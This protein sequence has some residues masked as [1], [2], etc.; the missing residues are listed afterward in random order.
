MV[1]PQKIERALEIRRDIYTPPHSEL[2]S[3]LARLGE[4][5][6]QTGSYDEAEKILRDALSQRIATL[7]ADHY[8]VG[9]SLSDLA[10]VG[11]EAG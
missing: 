3:V 5:H 9:A 1:P 6:Y 4:L 11:G 10:A 2:A 8:L 7:G